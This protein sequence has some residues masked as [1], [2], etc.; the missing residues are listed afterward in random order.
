[1]KNLLYDVE[2]LAT[3]EDAVL[4]QFTALMY[5]GD[6]NEETAEEFINN[7]AIFDVKLDVNDQ[8]KR[9]RR[10]DAE[11][12]DWWGSQ[13]SA[14]QKEVL[15]P[16]PAVDLPLDEAMSRFET[17]LQEQKFDKKN[18][19]IWQRG[20]RDTAWIISAFMTA[21]WVPQQLPLA[22]FRVRDLRTA[23]DVMGASSKLNGYPDNVDE[24]K[25]L[26]PGFQ[27]HNSKSDIILEAF[28]LRQLGV[29]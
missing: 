25:A 26:I 22:W 2:T 7:C 6:G 14:V 18:D 29:L 12:V 5:N 15:L 24:L 9:G 10:I 3:H 17:W 13:P 19:T 28:I 20:D 16:N 27:K 1:M 23:V 11:T 21:G 8:A 4:L